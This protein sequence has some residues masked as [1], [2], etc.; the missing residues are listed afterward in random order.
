MF[1]SPRGRIIIEGNPTQVNFAM[2]RTLRVLQ[3][4][5]FFL[6][7][8]AVWLVA[9]TQALAKDLPD[10]KPA[11]ASVTDYMLSYVVVIL[12]LVLGLLVVSKASNR[13]DR[14]RPAGYVEKK[15]VSND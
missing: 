2:N 3:A 5:V 4:F 7:T 9:G 1:P 6:S 13:R 15:L 10:N 12:G 11:E 8:F 14:D